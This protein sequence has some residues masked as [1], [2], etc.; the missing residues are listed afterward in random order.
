MKLK[1]DPIGLEDFEEYLAEAS[2]FAFELRVLRMLIA[3]GADCEHGGQYRDP[4]TKK[5]REFDIRLR[6]TRGATTV[7]AA[8]ECKAIGG[9]FPLLV[10]TVPR[11]AA[12]A[13][14][15]VFKYRPVERTPREPFNIPRVELPEGM[16]GTRIDDSCLYSVRSPVGKSTAQVGRRETKTRDLHANDSEF[17]E[18]WSQALQSLD[19][20]VE[21]IGDKEFIHA[22]WNGREH[23]ALALPIVVVPNGCL[24]SVGY[25]HDGQRTAPPAQVSRVSIYI[26]RSYHNGFPGSSLD[27]SHLEV[28]TEAGLSDFYDQFL[29]DERNMRRLTRPN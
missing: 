15:Q 19:D 24:W 21:E 17:F 10:S 6:L 13:Y 4:D 29:N 12:E 9:H 28:M 27:V 7:S 11:S 16:Q 22:I 3:K 1:K 14:H 5:Y 18:K 26:G 25:D 23:T 2:D 20:L 8:V